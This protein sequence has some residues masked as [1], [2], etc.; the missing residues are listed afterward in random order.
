MLPAEVKAMCHRVNDLYNQ[1]DLEALAAMHAPDLK[2]HS[3]GMPN[4][5]VDFEGWQMTWRGFWSAFP[6]M[7][8]EVK[9]MVVEGD[10]AVVRLVI[11]GT[12][13]GEF[14]GIPPTGK[15]LSLVAIDISQ[16]EDGKVKEEWSEFNMLSMLQQLGVMPLA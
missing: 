8:N 4:G 13:L 11:T 12:Q 10:K 16:Y 2:L 3:S 9:D 14:Q 15:E 7:H 1:H 6:N 5:V